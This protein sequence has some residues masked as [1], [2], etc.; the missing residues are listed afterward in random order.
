[1]RAGL[2]TLLGLWIEASMAPAFQ[3]RRAECRLVGVDPVAHVCARLSPHLPGSRGTR[4][5]V[6]TQQKQVPDAAIR[7]SATSVRFRFRGVQTL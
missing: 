2:R 6:R 4:K 5:S 3:G 7:R 1:M